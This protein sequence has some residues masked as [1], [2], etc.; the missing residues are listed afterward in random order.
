[1]RHALHGRKHEQQVL[2][3]FLAKLRRGE[4]PVL[5]VMG[6]AGVGKSALVEWTVA[7]ALRVRSVLLVGDPVDRQRPFAAAAPLLNQAGVDAGAG[8][9]DT[10]LAAALA[11]ATSPV[12]V[13]ADDVH[14][15]DPDSLWLL[16]E[17]VRRRHSAS[18]ALLVASRTDHR[19]RLCRLLLDEIEAYGSVL[20]IDPLADDDVQQL[21]SEIADAVPGPRLRTLLDGA[22]GLPLLIRDTLHAARGQGVLIT[23]GGVADL[24]RHAS[25]DLTQVVRWRFDQLPQSQQRLIRAIS[26]LGVEA[27]VGDVAALLACEVSQLSVDIEAIRRAGIVIMGVGSRLRLRHP[28]LRDAVYESIEAP[29]RLALHRRAAQR[30]EQQEIGAATSQ[31]VLAAEPGDQEAADKLAQVARTDLEAGRPRTASQLLRIAMNLRQDDAP[32]RDRLALALAAAERASGRPRAS[33][34]ILDEVA[35]TSTDHAIRVQALR[36]LLDLQ[37]EGLDF[38]G[39]YRGMARFAKLLD[40]A[41][42]PT[43]VIAWR[44]V[45]QAHLTLEWTRTVSDVTVALADYGGAP[46]HRAR[47]HFALSHV[48][49]DRG[50]IQE[51]IEQ[52]RVA[53]E[54]GRQH[55]LAELELW[56]SWLA[57]G[58]NTAD[59][60]DEA[61]AVLSE[62]KEPPSAQYKPYRETV[63]L[64]QALTSGNWMQA[65]ASA[66]VAVAAIH[67]LPPILALS[68]FLAAILARHTSNALLAAGVEGLLSASAPLSD[69][70]MAP[71]TTANQLVA[72]FHLALLRGRRDEALSLTLALLD[73]ARKTG[74][75]E[76]LWKAG[77]EQV[78]LL[79]GGV[80]SD[81]RL[82]PD[83][84]DFSALLAE[85][86]S[87]MG[88]PSGWLLT[89]CADA[90]RSDD[91]DAWQ[92]VLDR[93]KPTGRKD[94]ELPLLE[95][96]ALCGRRRGRLAWVRDLL[97]RA[98]AVATELGASWTRPTFNEHPHLV[99]TDQLTP[100]EHT[101]VELVRKGLT[102]EAIARRLGVARGTVATHL[103]R[104][105]RKL[106]VSSRVDL[107][108]ALAGSS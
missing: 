24:A 87:R 32:A 105:Y 54:L 81:P 30:L 61:R 67:Y 99:L 26:I 83:F 59:R 78:I 97:D 50:Y 44:A 46:D 17:L 11:W 77:G 75:I 19:D 60:H 9:A 64:G 23:A 1:M 100:T 43:E 85:N 71:M 18:L 36:S 88:T 27:D 53:V 6:E 20:S 31:I 94:F 42:Q 86:A 106:G 15:F 10:V 74:Q 103:T 79:A 33:I 13:A 38:E 22:G 73:L 92:L 82:R 45:S 51:G 35:A 56:T 55:R 2:S 14:W 3:S 68:G 96:A 29:E 104:A 37:L 52:A 66:Q 40:S 102:N 72:R 4:S 7:R 98:E 25:V 93:W 62:L 108:L 101:V 89:A 70:P 90:G 58:L 34:D 107:V 47:L 49:G 41:M 69:E 57:M 48:L 91:P 80:R 16:R 95:G 28:L 65:R 12:L 8:G 39:L 84:D 5:G 21:V 63:V 76:M